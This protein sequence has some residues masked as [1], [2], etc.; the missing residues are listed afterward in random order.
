[1]IL[2][3][4]RFIR[5]FRIHFDTYR[6]RWTHTARHTSLTDTLQV[7]ILAGLSTL[8][9]SIPCTFTLK[10]LQWRWTRDRAPPYRWNTHTQRINYMY[11]IYLN[12][13]IVSSCDPL[14]MHRVMKAWRNTSWR[15]MIVKEE[16]SQSW[17][18]GFIRSALHG[19]TLT[20]TTQR[21]NIK[22]KT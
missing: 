20:Y 14:K 16:V 22:K 6:S 4:K 17:S 11:S 1:M 2:S 13:N 21:N 10:P 12:Y 3:V 15:R 8:Y 5:T 18:S 7:Q 9:P 19:S